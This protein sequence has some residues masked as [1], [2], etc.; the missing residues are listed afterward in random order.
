MSMA[1]WYIWLA[2]PLTVANPDTLDVFFVG[3][4]NA[5]VQLSGK[6][7]TS[8]PGHVKGRVAV[9]TILVG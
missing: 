1:M 7:V 4:D 9:V 8:P 2:G 3:H 6:Q 5:C